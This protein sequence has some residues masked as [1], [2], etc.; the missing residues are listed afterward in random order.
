LPEAGGTA[1]QAGIFYQNSVA[2][3]ALADLLDFDPR[4]ARE[5]V[6]E[7]R[8][9]APEDVDDIVIRFLDGHRELQNVKLSLSTGSSAWLGIW[10][11]LSAQ[12][13]SPAFGGDDRFTIVVNERSSDSEA[14][15][16]LC[17]RAASSLDEQELR[18]RLTR[19]QI[20]A[21]ENI[22]SILGSGAAALELLRRT[23]LRHL[24]LADVERELARRRLAGGQVPPPRLLAILRDMAGS[25]ARRRGLFQAAPL[26]RRLKLEHGTVLGE[27]P[28][29]GLNAYRAMVARLSRIVVP[30]TGVAG[31]AEE[32]FVWPRA[33][34]H[35]RARRADFE[36]EEPAS[37]DRH[38]EASLDLRAFPNNLLERVVIVAGPGY[39]KSALLTA[40][41]GQLA[42]GPFVPVLIP[43]ASLAS[44]GASVMAF[45]TGEIS[46]EMDLSADW[47]LLAE[48][49]LLVLLLDGLDEVPAGA[50][51]LLMQRIA[52]F[53]ARYSRAP[54]MLTVR[55]PAVVT[56]LPEARIVELLPLSDDDIERFAGAMRRH[57]GEAD[58]WE[59]VR[60][61]KLYPDLDRLARI[62]LFLAM[63]L[64][65][66][67]L[68]NPQPITRSDLIEAYLKTLFSPAQHK[69][70]RDPA[71]RSAALRAIAETLAF[72]RLERQEIGATE[73]EVR[74]VVDRVA[75]APAEA[76]ALLE[77]LKANGILKPQSV[78][79]L[80][81][82]Y[83][84]V[85]E[86]LAARRL[87]ERHPDSLE[88]RIDDA[89]Q[90]PWAQVIQFALEL[91]PAPEPII[92]AMLAR[93]DD[94]FCTGLRL[95]GRCI[96]NGALV[97][98]DLR[99]EV[100]DRLVAYWVQAP[101][102]SRER[103]GRLLAD[104]FS[105]PPSPALRA[106]LHH[107]WLIGDGA[108]DIVSKLGDVELALSVLASLMEHD[109]SGFMIYHSLK[110]ALNAAGDAALRAII[111]M[112]DPDL[113]EEEDLI[114][115]S[116]L[117]SN[118]SSGAVSHEL[119]LSIA[120]DQRFPAQAR[121][122]AYA[123]AGAPLENEGIALA[124]AGLRAQDWDRHYAA[125]S[126]VKFHSDPANLLG[127]IL[128]D[129]SIPLKRRQDVAGNIARILPDPGA[130][131]A[132]SLTCA[133]DPSLDEELRLAL[134][135]F[136]AR[137]GDHA[138]FERLIDGISRNPTEYV[139]TT[140]ALFGHFPEQALAERAATL[141]RER[142]LS[143]EEVTR[144]A[145]SVTTGMLHIFE[146]DFGFG[147]V[148]RLASP[149]PGLAAWMELMENW[150]ERQDLSP[151]QRLRVLAAGAELGSE[152]TRARLEVE[153]LAINDMDA[154]EWLDED[155]WGH[156]LSQAVRVVQRRRPLLPLAF[157]EKLL[158]STRYNIATLGVTA[159][160]ALGD[161]NAL[162]RLI[163]LHGSRSEWHLKDT[164][165]NTIELMAVKQ[166]VVIEKIGR[167]YQVVVEGSR[168]S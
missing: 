3:L 102:Q 113:L 77:R 83:P 71:D 23:A 66:T 26:R 160:E 8:V 114:S 44:S 105:R 120:R 110:P 19:A 128:R 92:R 73:R 38:E 46:R 91:H 89:V 95:V 2:A 40:I 45:L 25:E 98:A 152:R 145:S 94:A 63:L 55:D 167:H 35:D 134:Q 14:L 24:P 72:E 107:H 47:Q 122:R 30:G 16:G 103:V 11:S 131:R 125:S 43:L 74:D 130:R 117:L 116:G 144:I 20:L 168:R 84:I 85:Q 99:Q 118:F 164:I 154:P 68:T 127:E 126:L 136:E 97:G 88:Q 161:A 33:R 64:V 67:D 9:E 156:T 5:R 41:A 4:A 10:R 132:F 65:T 57:L 39:G 51:P 70:V 133:A 87:I 7:V 115:L 90:R 86:Y 60:R 48:Q 13:S 82:P 76:E 139:A 135:L 29:W 36:D 165:A 21:F 52:T 163:N 62:P 162:Q 141:V 159:L 28:E 166:G 15:A 101:S 149:H 58:G 78:I 34:D 121:M 109:R 137:F 27:P 42:T 104:G 146:M 150:G 111:A 79:R 119:A 37:R 18:A 143:P 53:S 31:S 100:G 106:A 69:P 80:Q 75:S 153:V 157:V 1:T 96:A 124:L 22:A 155:N 17:E 148:L 81:F 12:H 147:G 54:W 151:R 32:L 140:V 50:R 158:T 142:D 108:G 123:L 61:L 112:M 59:L 56:G 49:G 138:A 93:P 6:V 129:A